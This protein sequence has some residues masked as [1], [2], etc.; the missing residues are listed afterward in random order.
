MERAFRSSL[1]L[2]AGLRQLRRDFASVEWAIKW[3]RHLPRRRRNFRRV[4]I[5]A[6]RISQADFDERGSQVQLM[7]DIYIRCERLLIWL[8][9]ACETAS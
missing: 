2:A 5:D 8:G 9:P 1:V 6:M 7:H 4:W 3:Q